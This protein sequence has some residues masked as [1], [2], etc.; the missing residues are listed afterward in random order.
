MPALVLIA[1]AGRA[2][3]QDPTYY[4]D[5]L[6]IVHD[7]CL[8]CH[9]Q[10]GIAGR[11]WTDV[12]TARMY[13]DS[14]AARTAAREMPPFPP[15]RACADYE[16]S[17]RRSL[18]DAQIATISTWAGLGAPAGDPADAPPL[19]EPPPDLLGPPDLSLQ[20]DSGFVLDDSVE[21]LYWCF[22]YDPGLDRERDL[23]ASRITPDNE[24]AVHHVIVFREPGGAGKKP[25]GL[26]GFSCG[27]APADAEFLTGWA[28]GAAPAELPEPYGIRLAEE[29]ALI[30]QVHYHAQANAPPTDR[31]LVELWLAA[32]PVEKP[33]K[34]VWTGSFEILVPPGLTQEV[35]GTC[36]VP[37]DVGPVELVAVAP[38]M[39]QAGTSFRS[40]IARADGSDTCLMDIPDW[41]FDWQGGYTFRAPIS[42]QPG[43]VVHTRCT[44][45]N[46]G[47]DMIG[48]GEGTE[49]EMC[50]QFN[51]AAAAGSLPEWC[52]D[53][54]PEE[55]RG[56]GCA[57]RPA[58]EIAV[59][60]LPVLAVVRR[61]RA[62]AGA[63][64][65]TER[66]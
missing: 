54:E 53:A 34:V 33:L 6:P 11:D 58:T 38:H 24:A 16:E 65:K 5:V 22:R 26:P 49:D 21:D 45:R 9:A 10:G 31:T 66:S 19:P 59:L 52:F 64:L 18:T 40:W 20:P 27:G 25:E 48:W 23:V 37:E 56:C 1:V 43:D 39:H 14:M 51:F 32:E 47:D 36:R 13:A 63:A 35:E 12:D 7:R 60:L 8:P 15:D 46:T 55:P 28:P 2:R 30:V 44:F 17:E 29:D 50:F 62:A 42:L 41:D 61:R 4:R 3:A 57:A